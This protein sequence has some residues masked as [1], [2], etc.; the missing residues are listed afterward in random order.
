MAP[1]CKNPLYSAVPN[2]PFDLGTPMLSNVDL[3]DVSFPDI[4]PL[5]T[6]VKARYTEEDLQKIT[7]LCMD[8]F[9]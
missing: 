3:P 5:E 6:P 8:L 9:F 7:K 2:S 4:P 1:R